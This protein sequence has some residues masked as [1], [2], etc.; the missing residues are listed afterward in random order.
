[1]IDVA[2]NVVARTAG[3][4]RMEILQILDW[5]DHLAPMERSSV[6]SSLSLGALFAPLSAPKLGSDA[7]LVQLLFRAD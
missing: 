4:T 5:N 2:A 1:V 7:T 6:N 3:A